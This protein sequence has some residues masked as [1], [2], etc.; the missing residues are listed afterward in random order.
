MARKIGGKRGKDYEKFGVAVANNYARQTH[1]D[2]RRTRR[3]RAREEARIKRKT[4]N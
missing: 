3:L 4:K 1:V 2:D